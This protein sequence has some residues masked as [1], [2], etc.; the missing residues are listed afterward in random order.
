MRTYCDISVQEEA[1]HAHCCGVDG[2]VLQGLL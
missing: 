1:N 2:Q